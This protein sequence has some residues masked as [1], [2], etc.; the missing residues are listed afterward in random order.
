MNAFLHFA[1]RPAVAKANNGRVAISTKMLNRRPSF[2][3]ALAA[4]AVMAGCSTT[5][6]NTWPWEQMPKAPV[7]S[8]FSIRGLGMSAP[9][10]YFVLIRR[11]NN[12]LAMP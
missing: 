3:S 5:I 6:R 12:A 10:G 7:R 8:Q 1:Q 4:L 11:N 2:L 9:E